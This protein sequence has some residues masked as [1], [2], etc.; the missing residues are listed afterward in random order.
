MGRVVEKHPFIRFMEKTHMDPETGCLEWTAHRNRKGYGKFQAQ[1]TVS[2]SAHRYIYEMLVGPIPKG[3]QIDHLCRNRACVNISHMEVV[4]LR[5]NVRR[6]TSGQ[7]QRNKTQC[8]QGHPYEGE[9]LYVD[10]RGARH[11]RTCRTETMRTL[12]RQK[13]GINA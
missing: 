9:N 4:T 3:L 5:E 8:P 2:V 11:C 10:A 12:R 1:R 6:G 13:A 7:F